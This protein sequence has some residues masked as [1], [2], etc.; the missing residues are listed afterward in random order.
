MEP[1][2]F[3]NIL[4]TKYIRERGSELYDLNMDRNVLETWKRRKL[5]SAK[6]KQGNE[7]IKKN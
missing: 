2:Q 3:V 4:G 5:V 1:K 6:I 7:E